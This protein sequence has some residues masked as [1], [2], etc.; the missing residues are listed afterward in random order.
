MAALAALFRMKLIPHVGAVQGVLETA[1]GNSLRHGHALVRLECPDGDP[2]AYAAVRH[3]D[4]R[5]RALIL[6]YEETYLHGQAFLAVQKS[7]REDE[8]PVPVQVSAAFLKALSPLDLFGRSDGAQTWR[9]RVS[10]WLVHVQASKEGEVLLGDYG[11]PGQYGNDML[12]YN[13]NGKDRFRKDALRYLKRVGVHLGWQGKPSFNPGGIAVSGDATVHFLCP[14]GSGNV[15]I[16]VHAGSGVPMVRS[17]V[18]G[19]QIMWRFEHKEHRNAGG[20]NQW[21]HWDTS[22]TRL[23]GEIARQY[24]HSVPLARAGD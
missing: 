11:G 2:H 1:L 17:S 13:E 6:A 21:A 8:N 7:V 4:G 15:Y 19:V 24:G 5:V 3:P 12:G 22:A 10:A 9:D 23:A 14:D 20:R 16:D 18:Q